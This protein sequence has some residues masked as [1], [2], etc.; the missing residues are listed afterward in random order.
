MSFVTKSLPSR[1]EYW[2]MPLFV[3][4]SQPTLNNIVHAELT[5]WPLLFPVPRIFDF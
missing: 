4:G 5:E 1:R 3:R 2:L